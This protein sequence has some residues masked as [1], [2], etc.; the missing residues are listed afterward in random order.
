MLAEAVGE[1]AA[2]SAGTAMPPLVDDPAP[3]V[4]TDGAVGTASWPQAVQR[5]EIAARA[6][7][8]RADFQVNVMYAS[9]GV[10]DHA[11]MLTRSASR[12]PDE[13]VEELGAILTNSRR[14]EAAY[15][16]AGKW[17]LRGA[18]VPDEG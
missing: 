2:W 8:V 14:V 5:P 18:S 10:R 6:N 11:G 4:A 16:V 3:G 7:N 12:V 17:S 1:T 15:F 9:F 13:G